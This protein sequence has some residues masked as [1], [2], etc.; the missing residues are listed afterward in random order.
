MS[1]SDV[2]GGSLLGPGVSRYHLPCG[3]R[4]EG[5]TVELV[6]RW[7]RDRALPARAMDRLCLLTA[8]AMA[9]GTRYRP[10]SVTVLLRWVDPDRV[11]LDVQWHGPR[12]VPPDAVAEPDVM[13]TAHLVDAL[14]DTWGVE[15]GSTP[16]QW[17]VLDTSK[18]G[19]DAAGRPA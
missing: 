1:A 2:S 3:P 11:R 5:D 12:G 14:A 7:G 15:G 8:A 4:T 9:A 18:P 16:A 17:M 19:P 6:R 10:R 13:A